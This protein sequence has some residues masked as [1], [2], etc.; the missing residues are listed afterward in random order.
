MANNAFL[1]PNNKLSLTNLI[2]ITADS[3][4]LINI[5]SNNEEQI[6]NVLDLFLLM[7]NVE[8]SYPIAIF[9]GGGNFYYEQTFI[10]NDDTHCPTTKGITDWVESKFWA[11]TEATTLN[12][13]YNITDNHYNQ[14]LQENNFT[15]KTTKNINKTN[16]Y[17]QLLNNN[18]FN[19]HK[20][21]IS[22]TLNYHNIQS[23]TTN[24]DYTFRK[25]TNKHIS[26][27]NINSYIHIDLNI[28]YNKTN[29]TLQNQINHLQ[30]QI[31]TLTNLINS[32]HP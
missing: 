2:N 32:Y 28:T 7:S 29:Q 15:H 12:N 1:N 14:I 8:T 30:S 20:K 13:T 5:D 27:K 24:N 17:N 21:N 9:L 19:F 11:K 10:Y 3:I 6:T 22:N 26:K 25:I 4:R 16:Y 23:I 31:D 18:E